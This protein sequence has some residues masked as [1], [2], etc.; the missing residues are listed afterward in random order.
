MNNKTLILIIVVVLVIIAIC[1]CCVGG[2]LLYQNGDRIFNLNPSSTQSVN[3]ESTPGV[4][5]NNQTQ[6]TPS[7]S[8]PNN[9]S[10][11]GKWLVMFIPGWG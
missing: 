7:V 5:S 4:T 2:F 8:S 6:S 1:V 11:G 3:I 10:G 9:P